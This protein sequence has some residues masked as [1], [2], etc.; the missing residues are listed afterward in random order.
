VG[1]RSGA[2]VVSGGTMGSIHVLYFAHASRASGREREE[3]PWEGG[4]VADLG[5]RVLE[6]YPALRELE[7]SLRFAVDEVVA[8][9]DTPIAPGQTVAVMPP[10]S[11]G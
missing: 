4:T 8:A 11:G 7:G 3:L 9:G 1:P 5:R 10:F 6:R 2:F